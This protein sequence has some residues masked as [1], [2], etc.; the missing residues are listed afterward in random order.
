MD[1]PGT[2]H[3]EQL[4][5]IERFT[6]TDDV[7]IK[8]EFTFTDATDAGAAAVCFGAQPLDGIAVNVQ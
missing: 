2:P 7:T 8:Y 3:T 4:H 5:L 6:R 1:R